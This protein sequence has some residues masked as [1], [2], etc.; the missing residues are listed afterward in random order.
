MKN[1]AA[2][3]VLSGGQDSVTC[4][5]WAKQ[6]FKEVSAVSFDY[7]QK[8]AIE[9]ASACTVADM[10]KT[11]H[12]IVKV[13]PILGGR[14]PLTNPQE[15]LELYEN[16]QQMDQVIGNRVE[17][18][19]VPMR[20]SLFLTLA[21]N[22]A[23]CKD[24]TNIVT[25]VCQADNANYPDCRQTFL[26]AFE[27]TVNLSL[28]LEP[29]GEDSLKFLAPLMNNSKPQTVKLATELPGCWEALAWSHTA[30]N[31]E[32]PPTSKDHAS[33][34]RAH[35]FEEAGFPDPLVVRAWFLGDMELPKTAN[36]EKLIGRKFKTLE[37]ALDVSM[38][39]GLYA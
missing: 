13:G 5:F 31:G 26:S 38:K 29:H 22:R 15:K 37:E 36:Y 3:V 27:H 2:L 35:G 8:H 23:V 28:G 14:S 6:K 9:L 21:A 7:G 19:F 39:A 1:D 18:T 12:E 4:L 11:P 20:N 16:Y 32:Y 17:L 34:L 25:G 24:I 33:T 30:Y 10:A